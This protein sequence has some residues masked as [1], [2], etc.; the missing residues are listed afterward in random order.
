VTRTGHSLVGQALQRAAELQPQFLQRL[1]SGAEQDRWR[2][3]AAAVGAATET[4]LPD[5]EFADLCAQ[6][7]SC[8]AAVV[9]LAGP[10]FQRDNVRRW[11]L[12]HANPLW[13]ALIE[14][15]FARSARLASSAGL[16]SQSSGQSDPILAFYEEFLA[17]HDRGRRKRHGVFYTPPPMARYILSQVDRCLVEE[18]GLADGLADEAT[19]DELSERFPSLTP[20][21]TVRPGEPFVRVLDPAL[22][23]GVFLAEAIKL[24]H[25]RR[26]AKWTAEGDD[27]G[28]V[29]RRWDEHAASRLLPRLGGLELMLPA[30]VVATLQL[31]ATLADTGF[32]FT[33]PSRLEIYLANTLAGPGTRQRSLFGESEDCERLLRAAATGRDLACRT[34]F[35]VIVGNPPFSGISQQHGRWIVDLLRGREGGRQRWCNYFE[36]DG[37]PLGERKT[38]LQDDYV[39]F[40]RYAH[41][42]IE[43]S[44][45]GVVGFVTNHGYLDNPTFR[46]VRRQ[47][48][49]TFP[50][51]TV[52]DLHG[53]RKK[54]ER[55]PDGQ[56]DENVFGIEQGTAIGLLR[57]PPGEGVGS[58]RSHGELWGNA[59]DKLN[60]LDEAARQPDSGDPGAV[61]AL[62]VMHPAGPDYLFLPRTEAAA[63]EYAAGPSLAELMPVKVTAPVTA[64]D[65]F[66]VAFAREELLERMAEFRDLRVPDDDIRRR[67]F[68]HSRSA[69][70][71]PGDTR[72][73]K[74]AEARR[75][76]AADPDWQEH[77]RPC[78]YRPFDR[79]VVYWSDGMIDWPRGEVMPCL[80]RAGNLALVARR[81]MPP[82][83]PCNYFW[84]TD[85]LLLDGLIRSDNRGSESVFPLYSE[86]AGHGE[87]RQRANVDEAVIARLAG[88]L[89]LRWHPDGVAGEDA[90]G[91]LQLLYY[92][93][94]LFFSPAY[95]LRYAEQLRRGFPRVLTPR[96]PTLFR[97]LAGWGE[98]L[99]GQ[100]LLLA[101]GSQQTEPAPSW[102][103]R[104][105]PR[106]DRG[107]P[108]Y[109]SERISIARDVWLAPVPAEIWNFQVG[110]YQ[111][112]QKWLK[113]RRGR[114]LA[115]RDL[116]TCV[117]I[118]S[119][120]GDTIR[121][122]REIDAAIQ[123]AGGWPVAFA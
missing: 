52:I 3:L 86:A 45:C 36:V 99:A 109:Q 4:E 21:A 108:K 104:G 58:R 102:S 78:W 92:S 100:H 39:K 63:G 114:T 34:P 117:Q 15:S 50:R 90:F 22:G 62:Q 38:W 53:N 97:T 112:C 2:S 94:A 47:L 123:A 23:T 56:A 5:A 26:T 85:Q 89:G 70:Y 25:A 69:K 19:W 65:G 93:Y 12:S 73:W 80:Q 33:R 46:G 28:R 122:A 91:P 120:I 10:L 37:R 88:Q 72:G 32:S 110:G 13:Q 41:W 20:P 30:C 74:L 66:V 60:S 96:R 40:L 8:G 82:T 101:S 11:V 48:L 1:C 107:F 119:A 64:R 84:I 31:V 6:A 57:R 42:K 44:G 111:V 98:R 105:V 95:R 79:R 106:V 17:R 27:A 24:V 9:A 87:T 68:T 77:V 83:Q 29:A 55:S 121:T 71:P 75:R 81:Q 16:A 103:V 118:V 49:T 61:L 76:V 115:E 35:T 18:F 67:Y 43:T 14:E 54:K 116:A 7:V 59:E 113:D 51:L